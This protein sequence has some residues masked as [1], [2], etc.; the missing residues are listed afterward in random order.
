MR[1]RHAKGEWAFAFALHRLAVW[2]QSYDLSLAG[3]LQG[4]LRRRWRWAD[5][6]AGG[7]DVL[8]CFY[9]YVQCLTN[10]INMA[11]LPLFLYPIST[12][13]LFFIFYFQSFACW[14]IPRPCS[15]SDSRCLSNSTIEKAH[16]SVHHSL[17][18]I[19]LFPHNGWR[20]NW[21]TELGTRSWNNTPLPRIRIFFIGSREV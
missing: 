14:Q 4:C 9:L 3:V 21:R 16:C 19:S 13:F 15:P 12:L 1:H 18:V 8:S 20:C 7:R 11:V 5:L 6:L 10:A 17:L 2:S